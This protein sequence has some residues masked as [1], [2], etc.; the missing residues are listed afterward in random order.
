MM[1]MDEPG[2]INVLADELLSLILEFLT[3]GSGHSEGRDSIPDYTFPP[4]SN[5]KRNG[6]IA[7]SLWGENSDLDR[8]RLICRRFMRIA[9]PWKFRR[10]TLR[11][12]PEGFRRLDEL[13]DMRLA[14]HTRYF[15]YMVRPYYRGGGMYL[16]FLYYLYFKKITPDF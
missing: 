7:A 5:H 10:F 3:A 4:C 1:M 12:S 9:T 2:R 6:T 14:H 13:V 8:F 15:T 11:F 16:R